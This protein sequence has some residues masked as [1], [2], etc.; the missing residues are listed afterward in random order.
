MPL[1]GEKPSLLIA[2]LA[3]LILVV[4]GFLLAASGYRA[5]STGYLAAG[6]APIVIGIALWCGRPSAAIK[7]PNHAGEATVPTQATT[8]RRLEFFAGTLPA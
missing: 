6:V 4:V 8:N 7:G 3:G 2:K 5:A 1:G